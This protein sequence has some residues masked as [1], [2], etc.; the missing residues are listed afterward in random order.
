MSH[1]IAIVSAAYDRIHSLE[2]QIMSLQQATY[3]EPVTLVISIDKSENTDVEQFA[4]SVEWAHGSKRVVMHEE[5]LGLRRHMLSLGQFLEEF[6]A[7][8]VLEDDIT[9]VPHFITYV[10]ASLDRYQDDDRIA[11]ISL[12]SYNV[13]HGTLRPF[14]PVSC[15]HDVFF[16]NV[17]MSWGQVWMRRQWQ[18][19]HQWYLTHDEEF[20]LPHIP[21]NVNRWK[22]SSWL[23]YHIRYCIEQD[24]YFVYPYTSLTANNADAGVHMKVSETI[25]QSPLQ[26][27]PHDAYRLP[28]PDECPVRYDGFM[29]PKF[30]GAYLGLSEDELTVDFHQSRRYGQWKR[31]LLS[32][33]LL[34]F[35]VIQSFALELCPYE[36][37]VMLHRHGHGIWLYDTTQEALPPARTD[38]YT[39]YHYLYKK[40]FYDA[41][42]MIG[43]RRMLSLVRDLVFY[44]LNQTFN[45]HLP[46]HIS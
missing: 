44:K 28:S 7:I 20:N 42:F 31:Y 36:A 39:L 37:N 34:P 18:A 15:G 23:K 6:D 45:L 38:R 40:G 2:R 5:N 3:P 12:Y 17:A 27:F 22:A 33:R 30:L 19:F 35:R 32:T 43:P 10:L 4:Q 29:E 1:N 25:Y 8:V 13:H 46:T 9:V 14:T 11:G 16:M 24:K 26:L 21:D 41:I